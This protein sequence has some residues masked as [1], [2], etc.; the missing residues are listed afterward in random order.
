LGG[1]RDEKRAYGNLSILVNSEKR[2][3]VKQSQ[4]KTGLTS[5]SSAAGACKVVPS[6]WDEKGGRRHVESVGAEYGPDTN[7]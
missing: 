7:Q 4:G 1:Q 6:D 2:T 3:K 5:S